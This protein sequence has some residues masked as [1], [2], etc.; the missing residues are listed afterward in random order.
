MRS[1]GPRHRTGTDSGSASL[2]PA[3]EPVR[4]RRAGGPVPVQAR[5]AGPLGGGAASPPL[6][7]GRL[8]GGLV[9]VQARRAGPLARQ[10][11]RLGD[12]HGIVARVATRPVLRVRRRRNPLVRGYHKAVC[13]QARGVR[14]TNKGRLTCEEV[15][16][17]PSGCLA[18][19]CAAVHYADRPA[20]KPGQQGVVLH[21]TTRV[22]LG[23]DRPGRVPLGGGHAAGAGLGPHAPAA[24]DAGGSLG[25]GWCR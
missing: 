22:R 10:F 6:N 25:L 7:G 13:E 4:R 16:P 15:H 8:V 9:P 19:G 12:F 24:G 17:L 1:A 23:T 2:R 11:R 18:A 5:R 21:Q 14:R 20:A 3:A